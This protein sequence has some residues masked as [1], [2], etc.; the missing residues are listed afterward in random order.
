VDDLI[1]EEYAAVFGAPAPAVLERW[2]GTYAYAADRDVVIDEP[3]PGVR[4][5]T[6]TT[7]A[8]ASVSLALGEDV[9]SDFI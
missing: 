5:V 6:V 7:G 3:A 8:G 4:L 1:L 2:V 9:I